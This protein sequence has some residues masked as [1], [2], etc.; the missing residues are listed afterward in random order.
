[1]EAKTAINYLLEDDIKGCFSVLLTYYDK[2][3][4]KSLQGR[5]N[6]STLFN[7]IELNT[8]S[9]TESAKQVQLLALTKQPVMQKA[10]GQ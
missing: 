9:D 3:Y 2:F 10:T 1:M 6:F 4:L 7:K 8:V 5:D